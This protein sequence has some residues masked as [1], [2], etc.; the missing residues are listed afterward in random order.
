MLPKDMEPITL[1]EYYRRK[2]IIIN[3]NEQIE[4]NQVKIVWPKNMEHLEHLEH[5]KNIMEE[6]V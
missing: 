3:N 4:A 5:Y 2:G 1:Q 6:N